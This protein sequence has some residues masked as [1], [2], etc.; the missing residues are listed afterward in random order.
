MVAWLLFRDRDDRA[1]RWAAC[2]V[3]FAA[4]FDVR[5]LVEQWMARMSDDSAWLSIADGLQ[6]GIWYICD[7]GMV[8]VLIP[9]GFAFGSAYS[10]RARRNVAL[11]ALLPPLALIGIVGSGAESFI[12]EDARLVYACG[13]SLIA[14]A[15]MI[16][17]TIREPSRKEKTMKLAGALI[18]IP[19]MALVI[20]IRHG[21]FMPFMKEYR[22]AIGV[23]VVACTVAII[24]VL[25]FYSGLLGFRLRFER[26][27]LSQAYRAAAT[28]AGMMNHAI[29]N[30]LQLIEMLGGR[31]HAAA[32]DNE[33]AQRDALAIQLEMSELMDM[34][35]RIQYR[36]RE[37]RLI[38]S[39]FLLQELIEHL[40][41]TYQERALRQ[42]AVLTTGNVC[43][44]RIKG[45]RLHLQEAI[46]NIVQN[47]LD[48]VPEGAGVVIISARQKGR[49]LQIQIRDNG[50]GIAPE[51]A[52]RIFEPFYSGKKQADSY[53][54]GL[55]YAYTAV[56]KHGGSI[57]VH[58]VPKAGANFI[59]RLPAWRI[60]SI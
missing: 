46:G 5:E 43:S 45:D 7:L 38:E 42:G 20:F 10:R 36:V 28:G 35:D 57:A 54:L 11:L 12:Y 44:V 18:L 23:G 41:S 9:C 17:F 8:Y 40:L 16:R 2:F 49:F 56:D 6:A 13:A 55:A 50:P 53:G 19:N 3:L 51:L 33:Q 24:F 4:G 52:E 32:G 39:V 27:G 26:E 60:E 58:N 15:L 34:V 37:I 14:A 30:K 31:L 47:A 29:K 25:A 48:E 21:D 59:V 22:Y 1:K